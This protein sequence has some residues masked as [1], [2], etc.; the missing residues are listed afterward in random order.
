[1]HSYG[2]AARVAS[3]H[4]APGCLG[5]PSWHAQDAYLWGGPMSKSGH[6]HRGGTSGPCARA[7]VVR[8][9]TKNLWTSP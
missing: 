6:V 8:R 4:R 9:R 2:S 7:R 3:G 1:M 5:E